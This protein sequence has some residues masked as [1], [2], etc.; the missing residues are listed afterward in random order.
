MELAGDNVN[1]EAPGLDP[2]SDLT[3]AYL[4]DLATCCAATD[5]PAEELEQLVLEA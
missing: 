5:E 2:S 3:E 4:Q 1:F